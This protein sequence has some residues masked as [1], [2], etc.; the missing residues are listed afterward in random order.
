RSV[1]GGQTFF[2]VHWEGNKLYGAPLEGP[3]SGVI[4]AGEAT[5]GSGIAYSTDRG[6]TFTEATFTVSTNTRPQLETAVEIPDGPAAGRLVAGVFAGVVI[7]EDG[8]QAWEPS[9]LFQD[10]RFWARDMDIGVNPLTGER[11]LYLALVD[12]QMSGGQLYISD[13]DGLT[14]THSYTF[15]WTLF[16]ATIPPPPDGDGSLL[17]MTG[18][19][20]VMFRSEDGGETFEEVGQVPFPFAGHAANDMLIGPDNRLYV[21]VSRTGP[22]RAWVY[23]TTEPVVV[24]NEPP[25]EIPD[26]ESSLRVYP[27]PTTDFITVE[28]DTDEIEILDVLGRVVLRAEPNAQIDISNLPAGVYVVR[29]GSLS[30]RFTVVR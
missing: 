15:P 8:G 14:W 18:A 17:A 26:E 3:N 25:P 21:A 30:Q 28:T 1:D 13:D 16:L 23:R 29:A 20:G 27:N 10:A 6:A 7:S 9:S 5:G 2:G 24:S 11:R 19:D 22:E 12:A 4:L